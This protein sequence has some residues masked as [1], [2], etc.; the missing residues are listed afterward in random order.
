MRVKICEHVIGHKFILGIL[1]LVK[2]IWQCFLLL[3]CWL[4]HFNTLTA[5]EVCV[6]ASRDLCDVL[7]WLKC[8]F[9]DGW[10]GNEEEAKRNWLRRC[11]SVN[12][13]INARHQSTA[14]S[15]PVGY[16]IFN[17]CM[18][19]KSVL[20]LVPRTLLAVTARVPTDIDSQQLGCGRAAAVLSC[21]WQIWVLRPLLLT[22]QTNGW[23]DTRPL[24]RPCTA[25]YAGSI[26]KYDFIA[27]LIGASLMQQLV[28]TLLL[29]W[30][31]LV[32]AFTKILFRACISGLLS[33]I[34]LSQVDCLQTPD[35][36]I[37]LKKISLS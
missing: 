11:R 14:F 28:H 27:I 33:S 3:Y 1:N 31:S 20:S 37:N 2:S 34:Y 24:H 17:W 9:I 25:Y 35:L 18:T 22:R 10:V 16:R 29:V 23:T 12:R 30:E 7:H 32:K 5:V 4:F 21:Q 19:K 26:T 36:I 8:N 6:S 15:G 13:T